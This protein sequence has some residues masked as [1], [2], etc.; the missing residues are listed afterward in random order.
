MLQ[1]SQLSIEEERGG[2][3]EGCHHLEI[4]VIKVF[5]KLGWR[6]QR[7]IGGLSFPQLSAGSLLSVAF[8]FDSILRICRRTQEL[9]WMALLIHSWMLVAGMLFIPE[10]KK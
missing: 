2:T 6:Q 1:W 10:S 3:E 5:R 4:M 7:R 9:Y 8:C